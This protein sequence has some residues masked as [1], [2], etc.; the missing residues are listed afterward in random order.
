MSEKRRRQFSAEFKLE[1]I[2]L[3]EEE[4]RSTGSVARE[5]GIRPDMLRTWRRAAEGRAGL[6][7]EDVFPGNGR[8]PSAEEEIR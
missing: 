6:K 7:A 5:L 3:V 2:R 8:L 1:A 4:G